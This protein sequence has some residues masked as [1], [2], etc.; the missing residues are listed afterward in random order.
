MKRL[1]LAL[2]LA[3]FGAA[4]ATTA[5]FEHGATF[6]EFTPGGTTATI[7]AS[8][9]K[10]V[11]ATIKFANTLAEDYK[12]SPY[13]A[14]DLYRNSVY[15][16]ADDGRSMAWTFSYY[17]MLGDR[18]DLVNFMHQDGVF[19]TF[20]VAAET[21]IADKTTGVIAITDPTYTQPSPVPLP[22]TGL[23]LLGA[24]GLSAAAARRRS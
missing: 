18:P 12:D 11:C 1:I 17:V 21:Y 23:L 5:T 7:T 13:S 6:M 2:I 24:M 15:L 22:A 19:G 10:P 14:V 9:C 3:P 4:A 20:E 8:D 16:T